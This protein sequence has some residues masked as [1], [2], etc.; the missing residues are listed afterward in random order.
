ML[1]FIEQPSACTQQRHHFLKL[2]LL[3][4]SEPMLHGKTRCSSPHCCV[5]ASKEERTTW[6]G[7]NFTLNKNSFCNLSCSVRTSVT[8]GLYLHL[9]V[10]K[11][12]QVWTDR[13]FCNLSAP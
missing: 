9:E 3:L 1:Q 6:E 2:T 13:A 11:I 8:P 7:E 12:L 5:K 4:T 10:E